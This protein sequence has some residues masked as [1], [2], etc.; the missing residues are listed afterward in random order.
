MKNEQ[1]IIICR[2]RIP[3]ITAKETFLKRGRVVLSYIKNKLFLKNIS[4]INN[5]K[6]IKE[7]I[8]YNIIAPEWIGFWRFGIFELLNF[9]LNNNKYVYEPQKDKKFFNPTGIPTITSLHIYDFLLK[10]GYSPVN[11]DNVAECKDE[12]KAILKNNPLSVAISATY[13]VSPQEIMAIILLI[14]GLNKSIPI[15][16]GSNVILTK[17]TDQGKLLPDYENLLIDENIY[18]ILEEN[19]LP[20]LHKLLEALKK[21][22]DINLLNN[23]VYKRKGSI[24]YSRRGADPLDLNNDFPDWAKIAG[25]TKDIA[26]VRASQGCAFRCK[27]CNF[28]KATV[29]IYQ[30]SME[31]VRNELREIKKAGIKNV[32]FTDDHF[33]VHPKRIEQICQMMIDEKFYFNWFAGIRSNS[34]TEENAILLRE[35]GCKVLCVGLESGD[36]RMLKLMDKKTTIADNQRCLEILDKNKIIAYGSFMIGFPGE[37]EESINN[38]INW[39]NNSPLQLYKI[40]VFYMLP[41]SIIFDE[42]AEHNVTYFGDKY[43][44]CLWKTPTID[45]LSASEKLKEFILRIEKAG[46][47]YNYSPMYAF[48]PFYLKGYDNEDIVK[49]FKIKTELVKNELSDISWFAKRKIRQAKLNQLKLMLKRSGE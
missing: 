35:S 38:T 25:I 36:D 40:Y 33:A 15:I 39:I 30:R 14:R 5:V 48:F 46:L 31:S 29:K 17:L 18:F 20:S 28:P 7:R 27:F 24:N 13:F 2:N 42:Q 26:F 41:G 45:S 22:T 10:K 1:V 19:G 37:T 47:I 21:N 4:K 49:F 44:Y 34:I 12:L 32:A 43:D 8:L 3:A 11:M 23:L 16:M 9:A 6:K